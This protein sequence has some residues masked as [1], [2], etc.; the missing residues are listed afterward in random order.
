MDQAGNLKGFT[1]MQWFIGVDVGGTFTDFHA[2][3]GATGSVHFHKSPSTPDN[4]AHA[5]LQGLAELCDLHQIDQATITRLAHGTTVA[6]NALIQRKGAKVAVITT[7][8]FRDLLEIGRQIRP[9]MYDLK[10][11]H[12]PPLANREDRFEITERV[13]GKGEVVRP[14][15][16]SELEGIVEAIRASGAEACA[17]SLLFSFL[18]PDHEQRIGAYLQQHMPELAVSL[19]HGVQPE[20]REYER[21]ST[22]LLNAYL[23]PV[24]G[25]YMRYLK[26]E[27][28]LSA[29][30]AKL[31]I[32]Q[33]AGGL[34]SA[35]RA[36]NFPIRTA[37]SGP[38]AGAV[39]AAYIA[40]RAQKPDVITL[41]M[42]GTSA[43]VAMIRDFETGI[44]YDRTVAGFPVRLPSVD[45]HT[46]G[47]GGGSIAWFDRDGL[48]KVGPRSAGADPGPAC[49][50]RGGTEPTVTDANLALGRLSSSLLDGAMTIDA[51]LARESIRSTAEQLGFSIEKT[52]H[53]ILGIV[54]ANMIRAIRTISVERGH[55]PRDFSLMAFGGA[56]ALHAGDVA[57]ALDMREII[58]PP[59]PGILCAQGL[60]VSDLKENFVGTKRLPLETSQLGEIEP[61][62]QRLTAEAQTWFAAEDIDISRRKLTLS[63]DLRYRRQNFEI[64]VA[65]AESDGAESDQI[66]LPDIAVL[67][68][69][70]YE[71]HE[72]TYGHYTDQDPIEIVNFRVSARGLAE[73]VEVEPTSPAIRSDQ[74]TTETR[75]IW[76][77]PDHS[78]EAQVLR[79]DNLRAGQTFVG[80]ASVEQMDATTLIHPGD[81]V[82]VDEALNLIITVGS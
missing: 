72:R 37:L 26:D 52:A 22:T 30:A 34:M 39:G 18:N 13:G 6:T 15:A 58:I 5:I 79:R 55:D 49:Y 47:A 48:L 19:S 29:P 78:V 27:I 42:G 11:D 60:V 36:G 41:D 64:T 10:A 81:Q 68:Q 77:S 53:G 75:E 9:K 7:R 24:V 25:R 62:I 21:F 67:T 3:D 40:A 23:Q 4:P 69:R 76:Y 12:P 54:T 14:L 80:P 61:I 56:G 17:V 8:G 57:R 45:I 28:A 1:N 82:L 44:S 65:A 51:T 38:A 2:V 73:I 32:N 74:T 50:G 46:I 71:A 33:S 35:D 70:F 16:E 43:D 66:R 31:G 59:A 63:L 20:F